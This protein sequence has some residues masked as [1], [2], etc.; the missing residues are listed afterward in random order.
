MSLLIRVWIKFQPL[1]KNGLSITSITESSVRSYTRKQYRDLRLH[2]YLPSFWK[3]P[4]RIPRLPEGPVRRDD[5]RSWSRY[6]FSLRIF[7]VPPPPRNSTERNY[8]NRLSVTRDRS[9]CAISKGFHEITGNTS[10]ASGFV[11][12]AIFR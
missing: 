7:F 8:K 6:S 10:P 9:P 12:V 4:A 11:E 1:Y 2:T 3:L 5:I